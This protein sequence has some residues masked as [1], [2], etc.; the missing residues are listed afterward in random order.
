MKWKEIGF[1]HLMNIYLLGSLS[2]SLECVS[3]SKIRTTPSLLLQSLGSC[4]R[5]DVQKT[6]CQQ[7]AVSWRF[8]PGTGAIR[9]RGTGLM[10]RLSTDSTFESHERSP[11]FVSCVS[12]GISFPCHHKT[13]WTDA[14]EGGLIYEV[15]YVHWLFLPHL[16]NLI[17]LWSELTSWFWLQLP[18][19]SG[20][21]AMR[22]VKKLESAVGICSME[23]HPGVHL[24]QNQTGR[25]V[26]LSWSPQEGIGSDSPRCLSAAGRWNMSACAVGYGVFF[27]FRSL[28]SHPSNNE[29]WCC[30]A[31]EIGHIQGGM[32]VDRSFFFF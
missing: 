29:A 19:G 11:K 4:R 2:N 3:G 24:L 16:M 13:T 30:L 28:S 25:S 17:N 21:W 14:R 5:A 8:A 31:Y 18:L 9:S 12:L 1:I 32:A 22:G 26:Y 15:E 23:S 6:R 7:P 27:S 10:I 20:E